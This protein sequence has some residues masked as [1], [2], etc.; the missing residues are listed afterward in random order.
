ME[1]AEAVR[2][3]RMVRNFTAEPVDPAVL[4]R[5]LDQARRAP[6]AG[7]TQGFAFLVLEG[8]EQVGRFWDVTF[9]APERAGFR[10]P[11]LFR[12]PVIVVPC[13]SKEAYLDRY[14]EP[15]KGWTD[16]DEGRWP[17]PYWDVDCA[18]ATMSLL[19]GA[20]DAGLGALFFGIFGGLP[21]LRTVFAIPEAFT[22]IGAV[23]LGHPAPDEPSPSLARGRRPTEETIH[24]GRW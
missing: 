19:L 2:R 6:S 8:A 18:F 16:R 4:D 11:G 1:F 9:P 17:V 15:D 10:W 12:A 14:A 20:V 13:S 3:R 22:P 24:R 5:L 21:E 7:H 23:A